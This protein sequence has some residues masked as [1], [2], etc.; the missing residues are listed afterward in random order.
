MK[1]R[2]AETD[3]AHV[4]EK[5]K[6]GDRSFRKATD[7]GHFAFPGNGNIVVPAD[8]ADRIRIRA[9]DTEGNAIKEELSLPGI[10]DEKAAEFEEMLDGLEEAG[11]RARGPPGSGCST[12]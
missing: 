10:C 3:S 8:L 6:D 9:M 2:P 4:P 11:S 7:A 5:R 1:T 12:E